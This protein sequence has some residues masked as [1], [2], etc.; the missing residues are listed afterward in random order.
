MK[1]LPSV[2]NTGVS[3]SIAFDEIGDAG[4]DTAYIKTADTGAGV[5]MLETVQTG[6]GI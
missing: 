4:R 5:W 6:S 2:T 3:G 1:I